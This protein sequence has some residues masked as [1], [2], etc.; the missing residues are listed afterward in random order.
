M[1]VVSIKKHPKEDILFCGVNC[2]IFVVEWTG[3]H[4]EIINYLEGIHNGILTII[5]S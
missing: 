2:G 5:L 4:F 3:S 1:A